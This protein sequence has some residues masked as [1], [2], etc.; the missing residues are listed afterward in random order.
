MLIGAL[1]CNLAWGLIDGIMY[2][3]GCLTERARARVA[4]QAACDANRPEAARRAIA[5]ALPPAIASTMADADLES[6]RQRLA[7][8]PNPPRAALLT[9]EDWIGALAVFLLV[10]CSTL[11]VVLPFVFMQDAWLA[12]RISNGIAIAMLF[13]C[14]WTWARFMGMRPWLV[15]SIMVLLGAILA[16]AALALGG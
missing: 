6:I 11:P 8:M 5:D 15:G 9:T 3:M 2:L 14:G 13:A 10:F 1:G 7:A 12:M 4:R 16:A